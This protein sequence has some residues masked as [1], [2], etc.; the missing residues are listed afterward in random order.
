MFKYAQKYFKTMPDLKNSMGS[1][2]LNIS[3]PEEQRDELKRLAE[4]ENRAISHQ[5]IHMMKFYIKH[6][7]KI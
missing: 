2:P 1:K 6:K 7:D 4:K 3:L 5:I